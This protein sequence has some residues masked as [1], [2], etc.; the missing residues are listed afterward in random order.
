[1]GDLPGRRE[2]NHEEIDSICVAGFERCKMATGFARIGI[3]RLMLLEIDGKILALVQAG[4]TGNADKHAAA[5]PGS[6]HL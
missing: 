6:L 1:M 5:S 4:N 2:R 3:V